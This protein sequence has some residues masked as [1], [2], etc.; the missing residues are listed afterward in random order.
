MVPK[1]GLYEG[2]FL[3]CLIGA[4]IPSSTLTI[5]QTVLASLCLSLSVFGSVCHEN[6]TRVTPEQNDPPALFGR[7]GP[8]RGTPRVRRH[9]YAAVVWRGAK[10][11]LGDL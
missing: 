6:N 1:A 11:G 8:V 7:R 9:I 4:A 10:T 2:G 5:A 3:K